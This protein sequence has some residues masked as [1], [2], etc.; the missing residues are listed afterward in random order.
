MVLSAGILVIGS[1]TTAALAAFFLVPALL[2]RLSSFKRA[3]HLRGRIRPDGDKLV[4]PCIFAKLQSR[5][6][7][8][9]LPLCDVLS[10]KPL[11]GRP[12]RYLAASCEEMGVPCTASQAMSMLVVVL[13]AGAL[14]ALLVSKTM[15][16][17]LGIGI[18]VPVLL[19]YDMKN[20]MAKRMRIMREQLPDA[21]QSLKT[22]LGAGRSLPQSLAYAASNTAAPLGREFQQV[23]WDIEAGA[24]VTEALHAFEQRA[25]IPEFS[26][27]STALSIQH[28]TGG[29]LKPILDSA[30]MAVREAFELERSLQVQT[31][32]GR[33]SARVVGTMPLC[34]LGALV[35]ISPG[36]LDGFFSSGLGTALFILALALDL[37]GLALIRRILDV[38]RLT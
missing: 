4:M 8:P 33:L 3:I 19:I 22:S 10:G 9:V 23:V 15:L 6:I 26:F 27:V 38:R 13:F 34:L 11:F 25:K 2:G 24:S 21:L 35:F 28:R 37:V 5:S 29:S 12:S 20:A 30:Q 18:A 32:Q 36:Y 16:V 17:A 14:V 7:F 31:A 1:M